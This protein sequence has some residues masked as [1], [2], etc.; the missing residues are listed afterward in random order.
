MRYLLILSTVF[1]V[2]GCVVAPPEPDTPP[3]PRADR[4]PSPTAPPVNAKARPALPQANPKTAATPL[5][6]TTP[7]STPSSPA[8]ASKPQPSNVDP[9][10]KVIPT[11]AANTPTAPV[12]TT[13]VTG[14][15]QPVSRAAATPILQT[16]RFNDLV[17]RIQFGFAMPPLESKLVAQHERWIL[18]NPEYLSRVLDRGGKYLFHIVE[19]LEARNMPT[20]LALLPIV[21]SAF[22]PQALSTAKAAGLWQFIP[23]TGRIFELDQNWWTDQRRDVIEST[24]AALDY[25]QK[26]YEL[27]GN[28]WFLALASYNWGEGAVMRARRANEKRGQPTDY[29]SLKM[30][31]ETANYV[32]KLIALRN[33]LAN[34]GEF[35]VKLPTIPNTPYFAIIEK[36][37]S[38]DLALAARFSD[39]TV[40]EFVELNP[41][42]H[43]PVIS[44]SHTSRIILPI[45]RAATFQDRLQA[46][47]AAG[48]PLVTWKPYTLKAQETLAAVAKRTGTTTQELIRANSL[49]RNAQ[50]LPG[51]VILAPMNVDSDV[52][53][54]ENTLAN[55]R[56]SKIIEKEHQSAVYHRVRAK[57]T[58][59]RIAK[60]YGVT[61]SAI[62]R[63]NGQFEGEVQV[64]QRLLIRPS[65]VQTVVTD[66]QG[67][68]TVIASRDPEPSAKE[69][70]SPPKNDK[71]AAS[72][73]P[74]KKAAPAAQTKSAETKK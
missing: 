59:A 62:R 19:E 28:D 17:E 60:R 42:H 74:Q 34:P 43:R 21:E 6:A 18:S 65:R 46:H 25:L 72:P 55:F 71:K 51:T 37:Q 33:I 64:G 24:R 27:Q 23:S 3:P 2:T 13:A 47:Q 35:G 53:G 20:E 36:E 4:Q 26:L 39:M 11:N 66:P 54:I 41:A 5:A 8:L 57:E 40:A 50:P 73:A 15:T 48:L 22:N 44:V 63:L 61:Q 68:K 58:L 7:Q 67:R 45:D 9:P 14:Q 52:P 29:L 12:T 70:K 32:P 1:V 16:A 38:I 31:R 56:G 69:K 30:P 49:K 10:T